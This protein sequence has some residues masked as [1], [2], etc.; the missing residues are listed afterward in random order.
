MINSYFCYNKDA[1]EKEKFIGL[2]KEEEKEKARELVV[3]NVDMEEI[4]SKMDEYSDDIIGLYDVESH[5]RETIKA[6]I[7][8]VEKCAREKT[9][10]IVRNMI[11]EKINV[12]TISKVSG[13]SIE[14]INNMN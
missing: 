8:E 13:L 9:E 2:F 12:E 3:G 5:R 7:E 10:S 11:N 1:S 6:K 4:Y 14:E